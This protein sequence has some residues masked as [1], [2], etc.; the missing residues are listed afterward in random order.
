[1]DF[2]ISAT[3]PLPKERKMSMTNSLL[4]GNKEKDVRKHR[5]ILVGDVIVSNQAASF[6]SELM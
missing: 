2:S 1:M 5:E 3:W 6:L 4:T